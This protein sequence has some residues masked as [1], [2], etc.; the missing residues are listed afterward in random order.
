MARQPTF[1][2]AP[3]SFKES[4]TAKEVCLAMEEGLRK[5]FPDARYVHVPMADGGEGTVQALVDATGGRLQQ[6][7]L[8]VACDV[9]NP[10][11]G[12]RGAS[13][14]FGSQKGATAAMAEQLDAALAHYAEGIDAIFGIAP[15]AAA[16]PLGPARPASL[17]PLRRPKGS[18]VVFPTTLLPFFLLLQGKCC[19]AAT[20]KSAP[21]RTADKSARPPNIGHFRIKP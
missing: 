10:L 1:V 2:L 7:R 12:E 15:G 3:D 9:D 17:R 14:V 18:N 4:M 16:L 19:K 13:R 5:A 21:G 6:T 11:C 20:F 8:I